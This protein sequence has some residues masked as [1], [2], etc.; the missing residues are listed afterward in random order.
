MHTRY[1]AAIVLI[2]MFFWVTVT[3]ATATS[4]SLDLGPARAR[5]E[6]VAYDEALALL[7]AARPSSDEDKARVAAF[8]G[9]V[10]AQMGDDEAARA[11]FAKAASLDACVAFPDVEAPPRVRDMFTASIQRPAPHPGSP[12]PPQAQPGTAQASAPTWPLPAGIAFA[13]AGG[14]TLAAAGIMGAIALS[15]NA[16]AQGAPVQVDAVAFDA[17]SREQ[18]LVANSLA[19]VG[20]TLVVGGATTAAFGLLLE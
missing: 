1:A 15:N 9:V 11:S 20:G 8:I 12:Q 13:A 7:E 5:Y 10:R 14:V 2:G 3:V 6:A 4:Q 19:V 16:A 18:A 17:V